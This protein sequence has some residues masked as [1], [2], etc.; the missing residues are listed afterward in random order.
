MEEDEEDEED[1]DEEE[2]KKLTEGAL[3]EF[4]R[5]VHPQAQFSQLNEAEERYFG[6]FVGLPHENE[7]LKKFSVACGTEQVSVEVGVGN[8]L[9]VKEASTQAVDTE[10]EALLARIASME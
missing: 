1:E 7:D 2:E 3:A 6:G 8:T 4:N 10:K 5:L 9:E